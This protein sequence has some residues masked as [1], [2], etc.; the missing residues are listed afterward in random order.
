MSDVTSRRARPRPDLAWLARPAW[1]IGGSFVALMMV[2]SGGMYG[3]AVLT[4]TSETTTVSHSGDIR[5]LTMIIDSGDV[6][7]E[8]SEEAT[9]TEIIRTWHSDAST[10]Q[11]WS[12]VTESDETL[13]ITESCPVHMYDFCATDYLIRLPAGVEVDVETGTGSVSVV[14]TM[15]PLT[16]RTSDG[17]VFA[18]GLAG[19]VLIAAHTGDIEV[20]DVDAERIMLETYWGDVTVH[21][22]APFASLSAVSGQGDVT[23]WIAEEHAPYRVQITAGSDQVVHVAQDPYQGPLVRVGAEAG[24]ASVLPT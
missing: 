14:D 9:T 2:V 10:P 16:V 8:A 3:L 12:E 21:T 19:E 15:A 5:R 4:Q 6:R 17:E 11:T 1:L 24:H 7:V 22:T 20:S 23:A 13:S 18:E